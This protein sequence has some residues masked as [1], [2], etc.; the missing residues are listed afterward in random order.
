MNTLKMIRNLILILLIAIVSGLA[1][2]TIAFSLPVQPVKENLK[3][4][5]E[6]FEK[7]MESEYFRVIEND[8]ATKA[9]VMIGEIGGS[10]EQDAAKWA[11]EHMTKPVVAYIAGFTAPEGKQMGH[12]GAIVSGGKGTAQ[13]KK[14]ALEAVGIRVGRTPGQTA[15]IMR[16][17]LASKSI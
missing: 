17:V 15:E 13:D 9:V 10:A 16:E 12:A 6:V 5:L 3:E 2:N 11:S 7:E 4:N 8:D 1:L 14:E